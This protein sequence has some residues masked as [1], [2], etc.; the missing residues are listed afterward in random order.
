[1]TLSTVPIPTMS[2]VTGSASHLLVIHGRGKC[3]VVSTRDRNLPFRPCMHHILRVDRGK[4][5]DKCSWVELGMLRW[6]APIVLLPSMAWVMLNLRNRVEEIL[7]IDRCTLT[8]LG[9]GRWWILTIEPWRETY[10]T[11]IWTNKWW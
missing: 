4:L 6:V 2:H 5:C 9:A 3:G 1:M 8:R 11:H 10:W 7:G